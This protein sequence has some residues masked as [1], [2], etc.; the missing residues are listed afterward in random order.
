[1]LMYGLLYGMETHNFL[2]CNLFSKELQSPEKLMVQVHS[3][4]GMLE[5]LP[6]HYCDNSVLE[7]V[8]TL[9]N[10]NKD[11]L[12]IFSIEYILYYLSLYV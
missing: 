1:M 8:T 2:Q 11:G 3:G 4:L 5:L 9:T 7:I 10:I 6:A 12:V